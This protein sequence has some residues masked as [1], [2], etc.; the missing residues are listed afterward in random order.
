MTK[1]ASK[2]TVEGAGKSAAFYF[3]AEYEANLPSPPGSSLL[4]YYED[5]AIKYGHKSWSEMTIIE[6]HEARAAFDAGRRLERK[7]N[8]H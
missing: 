3:G 6:K 8:K 1:R 7:T 5:I 2:K 4:E